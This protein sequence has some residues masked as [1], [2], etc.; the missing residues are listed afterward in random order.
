MTRFWL[1]CYQAS[2][3]RATLSYP[4]LAQMMVEVLVHKNGPLLRAEQTE[5]RMR[6]MGASRAPGD[7]A[8]D[9]FDELG[10]FALE[11]ACAGCAENSS[12]EEGEFRRMGLS[13]EKTNGLISMPMTLAGKAARLGLITPVAICMPE[14]QCARVWARVML[15]H[16]RSLPG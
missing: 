10:T 1:T 4:E 2:R 6:V 12:G 11:L 9:M 7:K 16:W 15:P 13:L 8:I 3:P 5:K 14:A